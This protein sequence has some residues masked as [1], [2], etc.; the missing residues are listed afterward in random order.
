MIPASK[1][2]GSLWVSGR[3]WLHSKF[4]ANLEGKKN[5]HVLEKKKKCTVGKVAVCLLALALPLLAS[6][7]EISASPVLSEQCLRC[8]PTLDR[9]WRPS[10]ILVCV[11]VLGLCLLSELW[12]FDRNNCS[13]TSIS[14]KTV[15]VFIFEVS[16]LLILCFVFSVSVFV[17]V[18]TCLRARVLMCSPV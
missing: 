3:P 1:K 4:E 11:Q 15:S 12:I 5:N 18:S 16:L 10:P 14:Y 9:L 2:S 6:L 17:C 13:R 7:R 8:I